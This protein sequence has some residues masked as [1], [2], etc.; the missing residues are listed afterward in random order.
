[1]NFACSRDAVHHDIKCS[2][3]A[4]NKVLRLLA[5][6]CAVHHDIKCSQDAD[7][8]VNRLLVISAV[9]MIK[10]LLSASKPNKKI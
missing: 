6:H 7:N 2:Q 9:I 5:T 10:C 1:M 8:K 3:D 4:D